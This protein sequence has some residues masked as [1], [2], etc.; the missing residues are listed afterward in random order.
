MSDDNR[1]LIAEYNRAIKVTA[2][3]ITAMLV[4][5]QDQNIVTADNKTST[6]E[7]HRYHDFYLLDKL[8]LENTGWNG[9]V[10]MT[11]MD[12]D[13]FA[14]LVPGV[15][16]DGD[17]H[18]YKVDTENH[19][20][21]IRTVN[22]GRETFGFCFQKD[23]FFITCSP[24]IFFRKTA[25]GYVQMV[26]KDGKIEKVFTQDRDNIAL[27]GNP[28]SKVHV[29]KNFRM[30]VSDLEKKELTILKI[31]SINREVTVLTRHKYSIRDIATKLDGTCFLVTSHQDGVV[32]L[33]ANG[34]WIF[35]NFLP[36]YKLNGKPLSVTFNETE[37]E[38]LV[39]TQMSKWYSPWKKW[40]V[41]FAYDV[42]YSQSQ[43]IHV[44]IEN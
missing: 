20:K 22:I 35:N 33:Q 4:M 13:T 27:F 2:T 18:I 7:L 21:K 37:K 17:I 23:F 44:T 32:L 9:I 25:S 36:C 12:S 6:I 11:L 31:D 38:L 30:F 39:T 8:S 28:L 26:R 42:K 29:D 1:Q 5:G 34:R 19:I 14:V 24:S 10:D 3:D 15:W 40:L 16:A 43:D 41:I